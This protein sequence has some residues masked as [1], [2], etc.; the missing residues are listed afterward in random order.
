LSLTNVRPSGTKVLKLAEV[1]KRVE[2]VVTRHALPTSIHVADLKLQRLSNGGRDCLGRNSVILDKPP[3]GRLSLYI[4][5]LS[6]GKD[7]ST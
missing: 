7:P 4:R 5:S 3:I 6:P 1:Q 2:E